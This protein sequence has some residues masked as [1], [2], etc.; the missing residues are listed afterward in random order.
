M[1]F[2]QGFEKRAAQQSFGRKFKGPHKVLLNKAIRSNAKGKEHNVT[3]T[4]RKADGSESSRMITPFSTNRDVVVAKDHSRDGALRS[5]KLE[6]IIKIA[7]SKIVNY[8]K[9][10]LAEAP[11]TSIKFDG[12]TI[13]KT[14]KDTKT[15]LGPL[16]K[17]M[18]IWFK[19]PN[20]ETLRNSLQSPK[21]RKAIEDRQPGVLRKMPFNNGDDGAVVKELHNWGITVES[22]NNPRA[23]AGMFPEASAAAMSLKARDKAGFLLIDK[24][25]E[26]YR[27]YINNANHLSYDGKRDLIRRLEELRD[28]FKKWTHAPYL[29]AEGLL[30]GFKHEVEREGLTGKQNSLIRITQTWR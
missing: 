17:K 23:Y 27:E 24:E 30:N 10:I 19:K 21:L 13:S 15:L 2:W 6:R 26:R 20:A 5:F 7:E 29:V 3:I 28:K 16:K 9:N 11:Y 14:P 8:I 25:V 18:K 1:S 22:G 12:N 4:Y